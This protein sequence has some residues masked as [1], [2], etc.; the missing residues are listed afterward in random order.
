MFHCG[1]QILGQDGT[2]KI[3]IRQ[4]KYIF[5]GNRQ[6]V[7]HRLLFSS[8]YCVA[9]YIFHTTV[10]LLFSFFLM[11]LNINQRGKN[12]SIADVIFITSKL[13]RA[14]SYVDENIGL[15]GN[16]LASNTGETKGTVYTATEINNNYKPSGCK[17]NFFIFFLKNCE[18]RLTEEHIYSL[19][20]KTNK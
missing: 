13:L 1:E 6:Y 17:Q 20:Y 3:V 8:S 7:P 4:G 16:R 2:I 15:C 14:K 18:S 10:Q 5:T 19:Y 11:R 12:T 9:V